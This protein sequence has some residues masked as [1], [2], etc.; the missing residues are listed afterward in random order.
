VRRRFVARDALFRLMTPDC[1]ERL[2]TI[3]ALSFIFPLF[4]LAFRAVQ[5][6]VI[7]VGSDPSR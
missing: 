1:C 6:E 5:D 2:E 7:G 4:S 3:V